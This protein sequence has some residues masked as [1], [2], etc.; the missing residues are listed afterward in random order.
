MELKPVTVDDADDVL[1][2]NGVSE[3]LFLNSIIL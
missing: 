2:T 3:V 1:I